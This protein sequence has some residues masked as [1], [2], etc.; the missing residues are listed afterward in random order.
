MEYTT[1][2]LNNEIM[3]K[4]VFSGTCIHATGGRPYLT[5]AID[6]IWDD[7]PVLKD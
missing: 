2:L 1:M 6:L 3:A 4:A 5:Q 7:L